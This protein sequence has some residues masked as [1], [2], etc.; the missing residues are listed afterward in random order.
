MNYNL[1]QVYWHVVVNAKKDQDGKLETV[2]AV[3]SVFGE[4][5]DDDDDDPTA[6]AD[7]EELL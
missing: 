5:S 3:I 6:E 7:S 4:I 2:A 1:L